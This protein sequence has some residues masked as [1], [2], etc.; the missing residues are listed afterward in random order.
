MFFFNAVSLV[1]LAHFSLLHFMFISS[2]TLSSKLHSVKFHRK[3]AP[4]SD[5][6]PI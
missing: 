1:V 3:P 4:F 5:C 2:Q 6:N